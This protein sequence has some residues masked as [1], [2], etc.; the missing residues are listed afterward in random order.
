MRFDEDGFLTLGDRTRIAGGSALAR[1]LVIAAVHGRDSFRLESHQ[2][3]PSV[4]FAGIRPT[5]DYVDGAGTKHEIWSLKLDFYDFAQLRGGAEAL[6]AFDPAINL[7]H[8]LG[9]GV[10]KLQ[11]SISETDPLGDCERHNN[12]IRRELGLAERQNYEPRN[13]LAVTP[14]ST[15]QCLLGEVV[16]VRTEVGKRD[17]KVSL[18]FNTERV[19]MVMKARPQSV[20]RAG[21]PRCSLPSLR[22]I[23]GRSN[24]P[25]F[26]TPCDASGKRVGLHYSR[27]SLNRC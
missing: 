22:P 14:E 19:S 20:R 25:P 27:F 6:A 4:A 5:E 7:L 24:M 17:K 18:F 16:F 12:R 10:L 11:D 23:V 8:E 13:Q 21:F 3:S 2:Q 26:S 1:E 15:A 9:H